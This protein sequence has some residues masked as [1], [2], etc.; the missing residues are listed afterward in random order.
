MDSFQQDPW[1]VL[2]LTSKATRTEVKARFREL[3]RTYHPDVCP[4]GSSYMMNRV[5]EAAEAILDRAPKQKP[6]SSPSPG[7][8]SRY[9]RMKAKR[10]EHQAA[11]DKEHRL[12]YVGHSRL[13]GSRWSNYR[14]T[15]SEIE[16]TRPMAPHLQK[17][18]GEPKKVVKYR[19]VRHL[20]EYVILQDGRC[21]LEL[22]MIWSTRL[23]LEQ[24]PIEICAHVAQSVRTVQLQRE[25]RRASLLK[26]SR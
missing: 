10:E 11:Y 3:V 9:E 22:E 17:I 2:G 18:G 1:S 15:I 21:D 23:K 4:S 5:I 13:R 16:I 20:S 14:I 19:D 8:M 25:K 24:L 12:L 7:P 26:R 6:A